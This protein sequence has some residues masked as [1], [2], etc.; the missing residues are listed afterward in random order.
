MMKSI[1]RFKNFCGDVK[2][3][4]NFAQLH[5]NNATSEVDVRK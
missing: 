4:Y 2:L 3:K 5:N 1:R